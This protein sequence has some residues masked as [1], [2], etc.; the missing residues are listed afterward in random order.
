MVARG[1][2]PA[3]RSSAI[4]NAGGLFSTVLLVAMGTGVALVARGV[5]AAPDLVMIYVAVIIVVAASF[6]RAASVLAS[7]L[8]VGAYDFFFVPPYYTFAVSESRHL[9]TFAM[10]FIVGLLTSDLVSRV[11]RHAQQ[12]ESATIRA[13]TEEMRSS[14][15]SAVSHDLRTPLAAITGAATTLR[16]Q[17]GDLDPTQRSEL[18]S[19]VCEE[20]ER[21]ERM[22]RNLLDVTRIEAPGVEVHRE[23]VPV[24]ELTGAALTRLEKLLEGRPVTTNLEPDLPLVPVDPVLIEQVLVNLFE[25]AAKHTPPK[26]GIDVSARK[27]PDGVEIVVADRGP[28]FAP[29]DEGHLF[30]KF[31]RGSKPRAPGAGL[32]LAI[33]RG[34]IEAHGGHVEAHNREGGGAEFRMVLPIVGVP[35]GMPRPEE[36][37]EAAT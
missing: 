17:S 35:P 18:I 37:R 6:G 28:G 20:A 24:E 3:R 32:G 29:G 26:C 25:N 19:T 36:P 30:E 4:S 9:I 16:D 14:I 13:R 10:M 8:S 34:V 27:V 31:Y 21:M 22:V 11:R 23:W 2:E 7:L 12:A 1:D 33:V 15:L 5:V